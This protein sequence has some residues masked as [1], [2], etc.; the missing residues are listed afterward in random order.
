MIYLGNYSVM[1]KVGGIMQNGKQL[2]L[3]DERL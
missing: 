2:S 3:D 1:R